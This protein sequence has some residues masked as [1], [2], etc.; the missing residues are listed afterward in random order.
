MRRS[1]LTRRSL[2]GTAGLAAI[3][4]PG[5]AEDAPPPVVIGVLTDRTGIGE[6]V[7]G[8]PLVQAVRMAVQDTGTLPNERPIAVVTGSYRLRPDDAVAVAGSWF[9]QG[10]SVIVDVPGSAAAV[11]V[12]ALARSRGR[13][14]LVT[15]SVNPA[16]TG[17][18]CSP[19]GSSWGIDSASMATALAGALGR[20]GVKTW[21]LIA[22]DTVLGQAMQSDAVLSIEAAGGQVVG[23]SRHPPGAIDFASIVARTKASG[24]RAVGLCDIAEDLAGELGQLRAGGLFDDGRSVVAFLPAITAIHAAGAAAAH[25]LILASPFYWAQNDQARS[26]ANRL[27]AATGQMPD[28]AHAAAYVAVRHYL[29]AVAATDGLDAGLVNQEMRRT[30]VYFFGRSALLRLDGRLAI[31]LSLLR[32]KP[33]AAM[34]GEWDHYEAVGVIRTADIYHPLNRAECALAP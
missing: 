33:A 20:S 16:L 4:M 5:R 18:D 12:Q 28:A 27:I 7:S 29:R 25:G 31:D 34:R 6:A 8:P 2:I 32:V 3:P 23:Q 9:D 11:A 26:F 17:R 1:V 10:V 24:A 30:P 15:G 19:F 21:F 14:T 13:S 22:P